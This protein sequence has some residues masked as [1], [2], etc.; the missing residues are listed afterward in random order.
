[1]TT[2]DKLIIIV[3]IIMVTIGGTLLAIAGYGVSQSNQN[4]RGPIP[5]HN[6]YWNGE[7]WDCG[8]VKLWY[9]SY[10]AYEPNG[11]PIPYEV[12]GLCQ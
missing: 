5:I 12:I 10:G 11:T 9:Q 4:V 1:M 2:S 3:V 7:T 8:K 6:V